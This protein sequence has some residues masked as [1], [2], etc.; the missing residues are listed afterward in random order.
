MAYAWLRF[1]FF[2][3][4]TDRLFDDADTEQDEPHPEDDAQKMRGIVKGPPPPAYAHRAWEEE[5]TGGRGPLV[6]APHGVYAKVE[7]SIPRV[8][9]CRANI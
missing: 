2:V 9:K 4:A 8:F 6:L 1:P 7:Y 5:E 3:L